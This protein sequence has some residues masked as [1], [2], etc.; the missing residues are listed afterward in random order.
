V[1]GV[2]DGEGEPYH[3]IASG[4]ELQW[5]NWN[6]SRSENNHNNS[7][8]DT[9]TAAAAATTTTSSSSSSGTWY[10]S[11]FTLSKQTQAVATA[12]TTATTTTA[13]TTTAI[14]TTTAIQLPASAMV[15]VNM[16]GFG[17]GNLFVNSHHV[18]YFNLQFGECFRPPGE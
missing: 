11:S 17:Q 15:S 13:A 18:A 2:V 1:D 9:T 5:Q 8:N 6:D 4:K 12:T 10:K 7:T 14:H 3:V 16:T